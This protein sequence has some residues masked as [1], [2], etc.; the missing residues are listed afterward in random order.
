[1]DYV[2]DANVLHTI[3]LKSHFLKQAIYLEYYYTEEQ[4]AGKLKS[5]RGRCDG[6]QHNL[7][8]LIQES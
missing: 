2:P 4:K 1:M 3:L 6:K 5:V 7:K 8:D